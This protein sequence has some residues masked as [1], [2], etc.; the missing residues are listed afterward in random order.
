MTVKA[1]YT[2]DDGGS[3]IERLEL[4]DPYLNIGTVNTSVASDNQQI[5]I[6]YKDVTEYISVNVVEV[7]PVEAKIN[8][9]PKTTYSLGEE[10]TADGLEVI[11]INNN[12]TEEVLTYDSDYTVDVSNI[13]NSVEGTYVASITINN[14]FGIEENVIEFNVTYRQEFEPEWETTIFGQS[15][16]ITSNSGQ[17]CVV[18]A[19]GDVLEDGSVRVASLNG[20][21]KVTGAHDGISYYYFELDP[22]ADNFKISADVYVDAYSKDSGATQSHDGQESFGIM[23]RDANNTYGDSSSFSSNVAAVGG[24]SGSTGALNGIQ[25]FVRSGV[26]PSDSSAS[27]AMEVERL[28]TERGKDMVGKTYNLTLEKDNTGFLMSVDDSEPVRTFLEWEIES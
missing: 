28:T 19:D 11:I 21:G 17:D 18:E 22:T 23:V 27:I 7:A 13:D 15:T 6:T 14:S 20:K 1:V 3:Y 2:G 4:D 5:A 24:Y 16:S 25:G 12:G 8:V 10:F 9:Y 26:D